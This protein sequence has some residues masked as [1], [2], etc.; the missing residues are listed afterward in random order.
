MRKYKIAYKVVSSDVDE[1]VY[2]SARAED[3]FEEKY[4]LNRWTIPFV[5]KL[6]VF[7]TIKSA[8]AWL[9]HIIPDQYKTFTI[10]RCECDNISKLK[11]N[12][13]VPIYGATDEIIEG[14]WEAVERGLSVKDELG[15]ELEWTLPT[16][17]LVADRVKPIKIVK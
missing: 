3:E 15:D 9:K 6:F 13:I 12:S 7:K 1:K 11:S 17:S 10:F 8:K 4:M 2:Y 14:F 16:G 5:G